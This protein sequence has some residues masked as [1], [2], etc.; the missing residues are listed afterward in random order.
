LEIYFCWNC[1]KKKIKDWSLYD[2]QFKKQKAFAT[3]F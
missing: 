2:E 3:W 1:N